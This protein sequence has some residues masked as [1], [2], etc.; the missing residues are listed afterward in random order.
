MYQNKS[1]KNVV[2]CEYNTYNNIPANVVRNS[3]DI[4]VYNVKS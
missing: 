1:A 2:V 3:C 4:K